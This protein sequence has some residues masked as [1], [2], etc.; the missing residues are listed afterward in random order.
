MYVAL[1]AL[2]HHSFLHDGTKSNHIEYVRKF[3]DSYI[4]RPVM[5]GHGR[6]DTNYYGKVI[7]SEIGYDPQTES[8]CLVLICQIIDPKMKWWI[9]NDKFFGVSCAF[10]YM[11]TDNFENG[12][13]YPIYFFFSEV[14][15][16]NFPADENA[17]IIGYSASELDMIILIAEKY[18]AK[19]WYMQD[20]LEY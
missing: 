11:W 18:Q 1:I 19:V 3:K 8:E 17:R 20:E 6:Y 13:E 9:R 16:T 4:D 7:H 15:I 14:T 5:L 12:P 2:H 10:K